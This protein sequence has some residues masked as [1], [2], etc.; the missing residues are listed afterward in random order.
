[1]STTANFADPDFEPTDEQL[2]QLSHEAFAD[3][4]ER[5]REALARHADFVDLRVG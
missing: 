4:G 3:V 5:N 1:M 2:Q